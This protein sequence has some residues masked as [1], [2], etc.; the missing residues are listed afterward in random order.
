[1]A[2]GVRPWRALP[3]SLLLSLA[4]RV[5]F[6]KPSTSS[7]NFRVL[8][9]HA[10]TVPIVP[11]CFCSD[12][13]VC[14]TADERARPSTED[15][16]ICSV[17]SARMRTVT[18]GS[19][20]MNGSTGG[21]QLLLFERNQQVLT[22]LTSELQLAG[23][24]CHAAR[25]AVEV[26][27]TMT[28]QLVRLV[29]VNLAQPA[30]GRGEFWVA[31]E[32]QRRGRGVQV[33]TYRCT[34]LAGYGAQDPEECGRV[35]QADSEVDGMLGVLNLVEAVRARLPAA[36]TGS[37]SRVW[38]AE[39]S[40]EPYGG[41][42]PSAGAGEAVL[43]APSRAEAS[44]RPSRVAVP[45]PTVAPTSALAALASS[46]PPARQQ[47]TTTAQAMPQPSESLATHK[48]TDR[49]RAIISPSQLACNPPGSRSGN[50]QV[51][52]QLCTR[53]RPKVERKRAWSS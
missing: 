19:L 53:L 37:P 38:W 2:F 44:S 1:M 5:G 23:Y 42:Q 13:P 10:S 49:V 17:K 31:M 48:D 8:R 51:L 25:T 27:A 52:R 21:P 36:T 6:E 35:A 18:G 9:S 4:Q 33:L 43:A 14:Y 16:L 3:A 26:F 30:A 46:F 39:A 20:A 40:S 45:L 28:H 50:A 41:G 7:F 11:L 24:Q 15:M 34:N 32:A 22:L 47:S 12:G 29:L